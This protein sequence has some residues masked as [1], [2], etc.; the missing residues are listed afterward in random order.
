MIT[1][2]MYGG[3]I[4]IVVGLF[5]TF[6]TIDIRKYFKDEK[7]KKKMI[8]NDLYKLAME[9]SEVKNTYLKCIDE[10]RQ[11]ASEG[12]MVSSTSAEVNY[13]QR[14]VIV[15]MLEAEGFKVVVSNIGTYQTFDLR[16]DRSHVVSKEA[17]L[18]I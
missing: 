12:K 14:D 11:A 6:L 5:I 7:G 17:K 18:L 1:E 16:F 9:N 15:S 3:I 2:F 4:L 13:Y 8:A 10:A